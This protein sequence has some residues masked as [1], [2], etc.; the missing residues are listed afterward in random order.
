MEGREDWQ[1]MLAR[2]TELARPRGFRDFLRDIPEE[3]QEDDRILVVIFVASLEA[4]LGEA[5]LDA[6]LRLP[7][8]EANDALVEIQTA[9]QVFLSQKGQ[10]E[11]SKRERRLYQ[12]AADWGSVLDKEAIGLAA[13]FRHYLRGDYNLEEDPNRL[14]QK[15]D[16]VCHRDSKKALALVGQAGA[17]ALRGKKL[18]DRW[19]QEVNKRMEP[20][21]LAITN[22]VKNFDSSGWVPLAEVGV[23]QGQWPRK[24]RPVEEEAFPEELPDL[25]A[26][27]FEG[28]QALTLKLIQEARERREAVIPFLMDIADDSELRGVDSMG[29]GWAPIHAVKLLDELKAA[30]AV[31]LL[32]N[33][34]ADTE[35]EDIINSAAIFALEDIGPPALEPILDFM[36]YS[37]DLETKISLA[38]VLGKVGGGNEDAYRELA[39]LFEEASWAQGKCL[40]TTALGELGDERAVPLLRETL[41]DPHM[42]G[43]DLNEVVW[44]L[45]QLGVD[46]DEDEDV[47]RALSGSQ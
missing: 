23:E 9:A 44:A 21:V 8:E 24:E 19:P 34:V 27:L 13:T 5:M 40:A 42:D 41:S 7:P 3:L 35:P 20:W 17:L 38:E 32:I 22:V 46:V 2:L 11:L 43:L 6:V 45:E 36:R 14:I 39:R 30:E 25:L 1:G 15:A 26:S 37:R 31:E 18:W 33:V 10:K 4:G 47:Q 12:K 28:E 29:E 16:S